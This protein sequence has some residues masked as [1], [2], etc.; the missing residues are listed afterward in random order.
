MWH[1]G[2]ENGKQGEESQLWGNL[3]KHPWTL[4]VVQWLGIR[5][6]MQGT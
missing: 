6:P 2:S 5:L 4:V 1:D 3:E